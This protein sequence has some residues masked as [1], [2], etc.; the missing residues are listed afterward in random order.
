MRIEDLAER[1][2]AKKTGG[3]RWMARCP[4]HADRTPS[5]SIGRGRAGQTLVHC[6]GACTPHDIAHALGVTLPDLFGNATGS[7]PRPRRSGTI[8]EL[9]LA[10]ALRQPWVASLE[11][12]MAADEIRRAHALIRQTR[13]RASKRTDDES[14]A[15][16]S[17][18]DELTAAV[19]LE[20]EVD[21]LE[22]S[23]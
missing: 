12:Y 9:A 13:Q 10:M 2:N 11:D 3:S 21:A 20:R 17:M 5:L 22:A 1:L 18:W 15:D 7:S 14:R 8:T 4:A 23:L 6:F 19:R 16:E